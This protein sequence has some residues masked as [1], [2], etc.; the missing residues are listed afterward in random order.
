MLICR[1]PGARLPAPHASRL[2]CSGVARAGRQVHSLTWV[3]RVRRRPRHSTSRRG[4]S[5]IA[6]PMVPL[7][8]KPI[9]STARMCWAGS[10][11]S[12]RTASG[13]RPPRHGACAARARAQ[14]RRRHRDSR[15]DRASRRS[16]LGA[17]Q[18]GAGGGGPPYDHTR[19]NALRR[20]P[21]R[22]RSRRER[23]TSSTP[24]R[25]LLRTCCAC[26]RS[27]RTSAR[28]CL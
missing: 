5:S 1:K 7:A 18:A 14:S 23:V 2:V 8:S 27:T 11:A 15:F 28:C 3:N 16:R 19:R 17:G 21:C 22:P 25:L 10:S 24:V 26:S 9:S 4:A 6:R 20:G 12:R 13:H